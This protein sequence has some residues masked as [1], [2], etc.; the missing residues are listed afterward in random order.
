MP[1]RSPLTSE[2]RAAATTTANRAFI[3]AA[4][5]SGKTTVAA[6]RFGVIRYDTPTDLR[7]ILALSFT[8]SARGE[9]AARIRRRWGSGALSWPHQAL[10][11]DTLHCEILAFLLRRQVISWMGDHTELTVLDTWRGQTGARWMSKEMDYRRIA[12][13]H[14]TTVGSHGVKITRPDYNIGAKRHFEEHLAA[15]R[16]THTEVRQ[17]IAAVLRRAELRMEVAKYLTAT[18]KA[19]IV[20][21]VF[22]ANELD[23]ELVRLAASARISTTVIGDPWQ[24]LYDF[25][26]ARPELVPQ[27]VEHEGFE[28]F[29]VSASFRFETPAMIGIAELARA[30]RPIALDVT[31]DATECNVVLAH[32]WDNLWTGPDCILPLSFGRLDNQTDA[33]I[34]LLL[35]RLVQGH[36]GHAAIYA[37]EAAA[38][39][40]L[41]PDIVRAE[42]AL[43]GAVLETLRPA[44][45]QAATAAITALRAVLRLLGS[46]RQLR[47]MPEAGE[48]VQLDRLLALARRMN[49]PHVVAGMTVH[50][51]KGREWPVVGLRL[52]DVEVARLTAGLKQERFDDRVLYVALTRAAKKVVRC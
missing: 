26:G 9:L 50:Q 7:R 33:A 1:T 16:C 14:G 22:D 46:P 39:L 45:T 19:I 35:D 20:D 47:R 13:L 27:L 34:A 43:L 42:G 18:T 31:N 48:A 17:I 25:R 28:S 11:L 37:D 3:V 21:E 51:A 6:E 32:R 30:H 24:A 12:V 40:G 23:L 29:P 5:G 8:R 4:P 36:F 41:E 2:Q 52:A 44:T 38:L 49:Q 15:G 10:T